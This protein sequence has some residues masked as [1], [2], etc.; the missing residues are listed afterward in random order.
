MYVGNDGGLST[1]RRTR[2]RGD[3]RSRTARS[4]GDDPL[5]GRSSGSSLNNGYGVTQFYHGDAAKDANVF[6]GGAQDNGTNR[7]QA[8]E[9]RRTTGTSSLRRR[10]RLRRDRPDRTARRDVRRVSGLPDDP[11]VDRR[12]RHVHR[13][14][15]RDHR[16]RRRLHH[17][18][19]DG[20]G[21]TP[22]S[23]G[24]AG[25]AP[26]AHDQRRP[27]QLGARR[28]EPCRQA[29]QISAISISLRAD[30]NVVYLG[31][32]E[33]ATWRARTNALAPSPSWELSF[34]NG[35]ITASFVEQRRGRPDST[36]TSPTCTYS[37]YGV[38]ARVPHRR[39][40][41]RVVD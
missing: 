35:L 22:T 25:P 41:A 31:F 6:V 15:E 40:A 10:R 37:N 24:P 17:A 32:D 9:R 5:P 27:R 23:S 18:V 11:E 1:A 12:R 34:S 33:R 28:S 21:R 20:P 13:G 3:E 36:P 38:P 26:L 29:D 7:V 19:R 4:H 16:H 39:T 14:D 30:G 8:S 2:S